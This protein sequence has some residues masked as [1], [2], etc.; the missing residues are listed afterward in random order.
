[1]I[2]YFSVFTCE[3]FAPVQLVYKISVPTTLRTQFMSIVKTNRKM[4][5]ETVAVYTD[6][7][8]EHINK[9]REKDVGFVNFT[10]C[11]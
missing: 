1:V 11:V 3:L 10:S 8:N 5:S 2:K 6:I 4:F 7:H 9:T